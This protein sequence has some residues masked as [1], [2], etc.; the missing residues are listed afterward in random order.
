[1]HAKRVP[2][3]VLHLANKPAATITDD[4]AIAV[5]EAL[6]SDSR[7]QHLEFQGRDDNGR[8]LISALVFDTAEGYFIGTFSVGRVIAAMN[9]SRVEHLDRIARIR[10]EQEEAAARS[11]SS[12]IRHWTP[13]EARRHLANYGVT[14]NKLVYI[15][16]KLRSGSHC[17]DG[18]IEDWMTYEREIVQGR[19]R[20][21][22]LDRYL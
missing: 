6:R 8:P 20:P 19:P 9:E 17:L 10:A 12:S 22:D 21:M 5:V 16:A 18:E 4:E 1:M 14:V 2:S 3:T 11:D 13:A 7:V 15:R